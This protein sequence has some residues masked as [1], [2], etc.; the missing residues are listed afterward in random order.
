MD[1][2][3]NE[4]FSLLERFFVKISPEDKLELENLLKRI[5]SKK[6]YWPKD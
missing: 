4:I 5:L 3:V 1:R 2:V 6:K